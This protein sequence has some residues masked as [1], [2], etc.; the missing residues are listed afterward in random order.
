[1]TEE[2]LIMSETKNFE[3]ELKKLENIVG[4]LEGNELPL[5]ES[6]ALFEEGARLVKSAQ[7]RLSRGEAKVQKIVK[8]LEGGPELETFEIEG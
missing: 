2:G 3:T 1:M 7:K 6:I 5:D 4:K 8:E